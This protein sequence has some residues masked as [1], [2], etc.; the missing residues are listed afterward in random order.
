MNMFEKLNGP[1]NYIEENLS[2]EIDF[3]EVSRLASC[4]A[5]YFK[6]MFSIITGIT[7][8]E[9]IRH[10]RLSLAAFELS[11]YNMKIHDVAI[12]YGYSSPDSFTRAFQCYHGIT[13]TEARN[14]GHWL[15]F[16][17]RMTFQLSPYNE[18]I[19]I[20]EREL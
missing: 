8:T 14:Q 6:R 16:Y 2:Y 9:Y 7:L 10:R 15:K 12:K 13:P 1:L 4:S 11:N 18:D 3:K 20:D 19:C 17:S 5:D